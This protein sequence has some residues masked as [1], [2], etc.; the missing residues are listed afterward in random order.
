MAF[1][2]LASK[3][4]LRSGSPAV[5]RAAEAEVLKECQPAIS[6]IGG[7]AVK[8]GKLAYDS[9]EDFS[10]DAALAVLETV[11]AWDGG[12]GLE[13]RLHG[14]IL[15]AL[16]TARAG[17]DAVGLTEYGRKIVSKLRT[18]R[19]VSGVPE[20]TTARLAELAGLSDRVAAAHVP[21]LSHASLDRATPSGARFG[22]TI[23]SGGDPAETVASGSVATALA[24]QIAAQAPEE[25]RLLLA[26]A[27]PGFSATATA[28]L[29]GISTNAFY[30]R[31]AVAKSAVRK[32]LIRQGI[33]GSEGVSDSLLP[34][35]WAAAA[36][37]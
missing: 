29:M 34:E 11:R 8:T 36:A 30:A 22:A 5:R 6:R 1:E 4:Q 9:F 25:R 20:P 13:S 10:Q 15:G 32:A 19:A 23:A 7:Q 2:S 37:A 28:A 16:R 35:R 17:S 3:A 18:A 26:M 27:E 12:P 33:T 14:K 21:L 31:A 24:E